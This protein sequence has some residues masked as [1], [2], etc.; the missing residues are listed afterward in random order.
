[1]SSKSST[2]ADHVLVGR[3]RR[4]HGIRGAVVVESLTD[5]EERWQVGSELLASGGAPDRTLVVASAQP[6]RGAMLVS[7]DGYADR[8][9]AETLRNVE[10]SVPLAAV[11]PPEEGTWYQFQLLG[12]RC[13]EATAGDLGEVVDVEEDGGGLLLIVDDGERR[14]P[15]PF[16]RAFLEGVDV[17]A[18]RIDLAL[19]PGL[20]EACGTA[21]RPAAKRD[22]AD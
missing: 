2:D 20:I 17:E 13:H 7:F 9:T 16:V 10:L 22:E 11:P 15:V 18:K 3:V 1:M 21:A 5:N 4:P 19:P 6:H 14:L 8:E 12:C